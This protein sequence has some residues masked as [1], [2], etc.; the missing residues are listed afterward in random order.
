MSPIEILTNIN[1]LR[2]FQVIEI[3]IRDVFRAKIVNF[4]FES[5]GYPGSSEFSR[6]IGIFGAYLEPY[7]CSVYGEVDCISV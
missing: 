1:H 6:K 3:K 7:I 4:K 5:A 2:M